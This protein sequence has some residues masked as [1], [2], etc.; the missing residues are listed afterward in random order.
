MCE[1]QAQV[2][3][4][5]LAL[6]LLVGCSGC[7]IRGQRPIVVQVNYAAQAA[8]FNLYA[9]TTGLPGGPEVGLCAVGQIRN[10]VVYI[11]SIQVPYYQTGNTRFSI[12]QLS[13]E[14]ID[15]AL[16][17]IHFHPDVPGML[18]RRSVTDERSHIRSGYATDIVFCSKA[19][20]RWYT[21]LGTE[22]GRD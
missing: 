15:G 13:C 16:G 9:A 14:G 1:V 7:S 8:L 22:G 21:R 6:T 2:R 10:G 11:T 4:L 20:Y 19:R 12:E 18:C 3:A 5:L 17:R